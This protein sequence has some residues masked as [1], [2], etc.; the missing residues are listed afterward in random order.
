VGVVLFVVCG[1]TRVSMRELVVA[2]LPYVVLMYAVLMLCMF[3]PP[4][5]TWLPRSMGY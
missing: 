5:V 1:I 2:V 3:Y 4:I